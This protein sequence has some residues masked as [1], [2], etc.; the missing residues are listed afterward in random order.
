MP[1][2]KLRLLLARYDRFMERARRHQRLLSATAFGLLAVAAGLH[3]VPGG[4]ID[5]AVFTGVP[6]L[7]LAVAGLA[8]WLPARRAAHTDPMIVLKEE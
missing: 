3:L 8:C 1:R 7:L 5:P 2:A 4:G 6:A